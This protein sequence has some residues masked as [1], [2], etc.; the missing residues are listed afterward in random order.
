MP[1]P[2]E[3]MSR[4]RS[5]IET[6]ERLYAAFAEHGVEL[7]HHQGAHLH[8]FR[9]SQLAQLVVNGGRQ[10]D[11]LLDGSFLEGGAGAA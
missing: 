8:P 4:Y 1:S 9:E 11:G 7:F 5:W 10:I 2:A 6:A 3:N